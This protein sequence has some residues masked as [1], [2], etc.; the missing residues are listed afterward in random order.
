M[1]IYDT[2]YAVFCQRLNLFSFKNGRY[3][4]INEESQ[5]SIAK[6]LEERKRLDRE[7]I[8]LRRQHIADRRRSA[9][10]NTR[11]EES[12]GS[13]RGNVGSMT[14]SS[15]SV[16]NEEIEMGVEL[17]DNTERRPVRYNMSAGISFNQN[18]EEPTEPEEDDDVDVQEPNSNE[19]ASDDQEISESDFVSIFNKNN[20]N[21]N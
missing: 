20:D 4:F 9:L 7:R 11:S 2:L 15:S 19:P 5:H 8:M 17:L 1:Q 3:F 10:N 16:D 13:N 21:K 6:P 18:V 14:G 12:V